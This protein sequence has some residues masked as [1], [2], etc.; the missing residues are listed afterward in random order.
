MPNHIISEDINNYTYFVINN[1]RSIGSDVETHFSSYRV[2][3]KNQRVKIDRCV[4]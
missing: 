1:I 2:I 4:F 3:E